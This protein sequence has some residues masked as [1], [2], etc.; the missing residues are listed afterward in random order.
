MASILIP[1]L[2]A[3]LL[4]WFSTGIIMLLD[5]LHRRTFKYSM[6][7]IS[8]LALAAILVLWI[9]RSEA[10]VS[11][12]YLAFSSGLAIWAWHEMSFLMGYVTGPWKRACPDGLRGWKRFKTAVQ[13]ILYHELAIFATL[14]AILSIVWEHPNKIGF[15]T[16]FVLW[17]MRLS[18]KI[19]VF[20]GV[21]NLS[22]ELL[23]DNLTYLS[24][25]FRKKT[26][27]WFFPISVTVATLAAG[28]LFY[29]LIS[30]SNAL[31]TGTVLVLSLLILAIAEHWLMILPFRESALWNCF[32]KKRV[33][34]DRDAYELGLEVEMAAVAPVYK[35]RIS[36]TKG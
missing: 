23:P 17:I 8:V 35:S 11:G 20:L 29:Q 25:F 12:A 33:K 30:D 13:S 4:W 6:G 26:I 5:G 9:T 16:F 32:N 19:N 27:N 28:G 15:W 3:I 21:P 14:V 36:T 1:A 7:W 34:S 22:V 18:A 10:S 31:T 2:F 24:T